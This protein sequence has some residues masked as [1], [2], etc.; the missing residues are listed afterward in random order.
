MDIE[1]SNFVKTKLNAGQ[2]CDE[3]YGL[4]NY[5][6][7]SNVDRFFS[8]KYVRFNPKLLQ[9]KAAIL[10]LLF[11]QWQLP[12]PKLVISVTGGA[13]RFI[14]HNRVLQNFNRSLVGFHSLTFI[15]LI[16]FFS[17]VA[18]SN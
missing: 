7:Q 10:E 5:H 1:W 4:T 12:K 17:L 3:A 2:N 6:G 16:H 9:D 15:S 14:M 13:R 11:E 8:S 18:G